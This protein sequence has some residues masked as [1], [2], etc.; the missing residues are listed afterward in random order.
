MPNIR[1]GYGSDFV[2]KD[3]KVGIGSEEPRALLDVRGTLKGDF[4][5][6]GVSTLTVYGGFAA[7]KQNITKDSSIGFSTTGIGT[8]GITSFISV[9]EK[10]TGFLSL[11]GE[12]NTI[13]E[14]L[15]VD[16]GKIFEVSTTNITGITTLGTQEVYAPDDSVVSVGTL[17][18]V[19]IQSHF[20]FPDGGSNDRPDQPT[21]GMVRF[22]DDLNT[23]EFYNGIEWRQFTVSGAS[24]RA[25]YAGG[26]NS[27]SPG[28]TDHIEYITLSTLGNSIS[29]GNLRQL[30]RLFRGG[31]SETRG[32]FAPG[33]KFPTNMEYI[34]LAS[35]G[36]SIQFD[37]SMPNGRGITS[38][39]SSSTRGLV[40]GGW[41][42]PLAENYITYF[43]IAQLGTA[44]D[45]GDLSQVKYGMGGM[46]S[47]TR[48]IFAG[49]YTGNPLTAALAAGMDYIT[50]ASKGNG[51]DFGDP[52]IGH[53]Y[54]ADGSDGVRGI[55]A[56][57]VG[58]Y[59][60]GQTPN[61][62]IDYVNI[63]SLG[64]A[65]NFGNLTR[66][67]RHCSGASSKTRMVAFSGSTSV[68]SPDASLLT[69]IDYIQ[70][71]AGG[72]AQ[73]FGELSVPTFGSAGVSDS[74]GG[75]GGF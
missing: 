74:H 48:G 50:I 30:E 68:P 13:S 5:I 15:I 17:E 57:G 19:S 38:A 32:V 60:S 22:N 40:G 47:P 42:S 25:I 39:L 24:G 11:V 62:V 64:N 9:N 10:E 52:T 20:G 23:L 49:G 71:S 72:A 1:V 18:S 8:V 34:T 58:N 69:D 29:F 53:A 3:Q 67:K 54:P 28:G 21:E 7:Q 45:F 56:G 44:T 70:I 55:F 16:E 66:A 61:D 37:G 59:P 43:E 51:V 35:G 2:V 36:E 31:S 6:T 12:Y 33:D 27:G 41:D 65:V 4:N 75:L 14:D 26:G 46:A 73:D 63:G